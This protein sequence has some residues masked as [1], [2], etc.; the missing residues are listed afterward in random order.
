ML[1]LLLFFLVL[2]LLVLLYYRN[3][4]LLKFPSLNRRYQRLPTIFSTSSFQHDI[5]EGLTSETFDLQE[6]IANGDSRAGLED[7]EEIKHI[8]KVEGLNFDQAR[9]LRMQRKFKSNNI[10]PLTGLPR[11]PKLVTFS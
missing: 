2:V 11:D 4:L 5:E 8:M 10:D 9:L 1:K 3:A 6:N 7:S